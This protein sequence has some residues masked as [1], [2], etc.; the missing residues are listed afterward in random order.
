M[1]SISRPERNARIGLPTWGLGKGLTSYGRKNRAG[2]GKL[3][4]TASFGKKLSN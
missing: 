2:Y 1:C 4:R 3:H